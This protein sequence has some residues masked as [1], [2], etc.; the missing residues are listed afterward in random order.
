MDFHYLIEQV[1]S[2]SVFTKTTGTKSREHEYRGTKI[3]YNEVH[4]LLVF[5]EMKLLLS[6]PKLKNTNIE[7][8][9]WTF[10]AN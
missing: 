7:G 5:I 4:S 1:H 8:P 10:T 6:R 2:L 9:T 3:D